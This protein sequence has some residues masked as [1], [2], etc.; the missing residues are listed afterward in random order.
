MPSSFPAFPSVPVAGT[1]HP[2]QH[3]PRL[4]DLQKH[5]PPHQCV[6]FPRP[7][8]LQ[9]RLCCRPRTS[10]RHPAREGGR[11]RPG[12]LPPRGL[13]GQG[14]WGPCHRAVGPRRAEACCRRLAG[15]AGVMGGYPGRG[16]R[17][18]VTGPGHGQ[19]QAAA[20]R[21]SCHPWARDSRLG[22]ADRRQVPR[23]GSEGCLSPGPQAPT[24]PVGCRLF[25]GKWSPALRVAPTAC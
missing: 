12:V 10:E 1:G 8:H 24:S 23:A 3:S 19:S 6:R 4:S 18:R 7:E 14:S 2:T 16:A 13:S 25:K 17:A 15:R 11:A 20:R 9:G 5:P 22:R 21:A